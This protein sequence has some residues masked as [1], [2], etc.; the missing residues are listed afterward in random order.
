MDVFL[1]NESKNIKLEVGVLKRIKKKNVDF[2][3]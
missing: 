1:L 2:D 3:F